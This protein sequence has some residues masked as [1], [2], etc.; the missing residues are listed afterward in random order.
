MGARSCYANIQADKCVCF[1]TDSLKMGFVKMNTLHSQEQQRCW[2]LPAVNPAI[3]FLT[4][5]LSS[6]HSVQCDA[7]RGEPAA[8]QLAGG[9]CHP[10]TAELERVPRVL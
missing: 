7:K 4:W 1:M 9:G 8:V 2:V 6:L 10:I 3:R 5:C